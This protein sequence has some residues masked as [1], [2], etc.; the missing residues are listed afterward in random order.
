LGHVEKQGRSGRGIRELGGVMANEAT[1][2]FHS[3]IQYNVK[4]GDRSVYRQNT[5]LVIPIKTIFVHPKFSTTIVVKNDIAL[6]KLQHPVNFTT[7]IYPVCIPS[8]SFPVKAGTKCW[9]TG[10]G[11]LVPGGKTGA[12]KTFF[13]G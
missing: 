8:E 9:V 12:Q 2:F 4:V 13:L 1:H 7:N 11:K 5:S 10:W 6:L 3:R